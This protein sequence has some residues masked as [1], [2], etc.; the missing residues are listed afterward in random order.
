MFDVSLATLEFE[1]DKTVYLLKEAS[2]RAVKEYFESVKGM[3]KDDNTLID[4]MAKFTGECLTV[5]GIPLGA[6]KTLDTFSYRQIEKLFTKAL[7]LTGLIKDE[8]ND[9][10]A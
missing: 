9:P 8:G 2:S 10:K 1:Y 3:G 4:V 6:Q 7:E 5:K